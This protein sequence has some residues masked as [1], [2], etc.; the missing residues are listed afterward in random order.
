MGRAGCQQLGMLESQ[1]PAAAQRNW[2][3]LPPTPARPPSHLLHEGW[4]DE[5]AL[6]G[7][8]SGRDQ[9]GDGEQGIP[10][11][12][13]RTLWKACFFGEENGNDADT[14]LD[15]IQNMLV[16]ELCYFTAT[17]TPSAKCLHL[18]LDVHAEYGAYILRHFDMLDQ[19]CDW[20]TKLSAVTRQI[21][22]DDSLTDADCKLESI[23]AFLFANDCVLS[24]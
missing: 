24:H 6:T 9:L 3:G 21:L 13:V 5:N 20:H 17:E 19:V 11:V 15:T 12:V 16:K 10:I 8:V 7:D 18:S 2:I 14:L 22:L 1:R 23:C 4:V